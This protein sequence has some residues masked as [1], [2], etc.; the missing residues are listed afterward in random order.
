MILALDWTV[1]VRYGTEQARAMTDYYSKKSGRPNP[2]PLLAFTEE[3]G[4]AGRGGD[5]GPQHLG[6]QRD[7]A[8]LP[9][10]PSSS[11]RL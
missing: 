7:R 9:P 5:G 10:G 2:H 11:S 4:A 6:A 3:P 8:H 1:V